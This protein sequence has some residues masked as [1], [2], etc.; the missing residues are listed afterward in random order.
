M[1]IKGLTKEELRG[2]YALIIENRDSAKLQ[3]ASGLS[4]LDSINLVNKLRVALE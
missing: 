4:Y 1:N 2:I 3:R